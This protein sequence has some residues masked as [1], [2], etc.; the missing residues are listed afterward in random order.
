MAHCTALPRDLAVATKPIKGGDG[1][2]P[3]PPGPTL[4]GTCSASCE[5]HVLSQNTAVLGSCS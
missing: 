4:G 1:L 3:A 5:A 2:F